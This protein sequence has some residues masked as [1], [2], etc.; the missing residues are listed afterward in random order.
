MFEIYDFAFVF[1]VFYYFLFKGGVVLLSF[2]ERRDCFFVIF[3]I[4]NLIS[5]S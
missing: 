1:C 2:D 5:F 4:I 3:V